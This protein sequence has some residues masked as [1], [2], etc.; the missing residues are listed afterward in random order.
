MCVGVT[1]VALYDTLGV[2][3]S[4]FVID[5][6]EMTTIAASKDLFPKIV[7]M[8]EADRNSS[9]QKLHRL[10]NMICFEEGLDSALASRAD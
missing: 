10:R 1:T 7:D 9:E 8:I 5:Q 6:T 2:E 3:A 4:R